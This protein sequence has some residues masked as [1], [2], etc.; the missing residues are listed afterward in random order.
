MHVGTASGRDSAIAGINDN[1]AGADGETAQIRR[2]N[3]VKSPSHTSSGQG[4]TQKSSDNIGG[5]LDGDNSNECG[6]TRIHTSSFDLNRTNRNTESSSTSVSV[7]HGPG[8]KDSR[9]TSICKHDVRSPEDQSGGSGASTEIC[10][11]CQGKTVCSECSVG[12]GM[13]FTCVS[14][15]KVIQ[16]GSSKPTGSEGIEQGNAGGIDEHPLNADGICVECRAGS[17]RP[18]TCV[19]CS[20]V[21]QMGNGKQPDSEG[22]KQ[23]NA[24]GINKHR[25]NAQGAPFTCVSC[26]KVVHMGDSMLQDTKGINNSNINATDQHQSL[27]NALCHHELCRNADLKA[28]NSD[29]LKAEMKFRSAMPKDQ[30]SA[31]NTLD[32]TAG[33]APCRACLIAT[34]ERNLHQVN[35][36]TGNA[37]HSDSSLVS[38]A[39]MN[40][41]LAVQSDAL[42]MGDARIRSELEKGGVCLAD[43]VYSSTTKTAGIKDVN[44]GN[45]SYGTAIQ[46]TCGLR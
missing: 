11:S 28:Q 23:G 20:K 1:G 9:V 26:C 19:S 39:H 14:C 41:A 13:P 10:I 36:T 30:L 21:V 15:S 34:S 16:M 18:F 38:A 32:T 29:D 5:D 44:L 24:G 43:R 35:S 25:S 12:D 42:L 45:Y 27:C 46:H 22:I 6:D 7:G 8:A 2:R 31:V 3:A 37:S 40:S 17:G 4:Y 33:N